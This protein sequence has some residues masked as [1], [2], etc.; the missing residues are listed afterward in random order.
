MILTMN[1]LWRERHCFD[2]TLLEAVE[3]TLSPFIYR[4]LERPGQESFER[5][6]TL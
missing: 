1:S 2:L 3:D 4:H 6:R 5:G